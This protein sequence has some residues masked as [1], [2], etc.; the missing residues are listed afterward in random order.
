MERA[1]IIVAGIVT[2]FLLVT[3]L[4]PFVT[5]L[6]GCYQIGSWIG[7]LIHNKLNN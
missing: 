3:F 4:P 6:I 2:C 7:N 1:G 5:Y